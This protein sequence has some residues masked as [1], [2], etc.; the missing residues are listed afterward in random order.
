M[1]CINSK[2]CEHKTEC[3][4]EACDDFVPVVTNAR[5]ENTLVTEYKIL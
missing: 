1:S 4:P 5:L 2:F 3:D